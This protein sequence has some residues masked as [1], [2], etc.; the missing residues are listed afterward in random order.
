M[1]KRSLNEAISTEL[2]SKFDLDKFKDKKLLNKSIMFKE[3]EWLPLSAAAND[4]ISL[5]GI[6]LGQITLIRGHSD[7]GKTTLMIEAA[8]AA[9]KAGKLPVFIITEMKWNFSHAKEMGFQVEEII[10]EETKEISYTG[11]FLYVDRDNINTVED[12]AEF[13]LDLLNEQEKDNLPYDLVFLWDSVGSIPCRQSVE[14]GTNNPMWNAGAMSTQFGNFI[15]QKF[16][17]SRKVSSKYTNTMIAVNKIRV[18]VPTTPLSQPKMKNKGGDTMYWDAA[19]VITF[20]NITNSG[21]SKIKAQKDKK[22]VEFAKRTTISVDKNHITEASTRN[23]IIITAHGFIG[24]DPKELKKYKD[25]HSHE[26][27]ETLGGKDFDIVEEDEMDEDITNQS[28]D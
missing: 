17:H 3:Q 23:V 14:K 8:I 24:N 19:L 28:E 5:P 4:G 11:N 16:P 21:V 9:Q 22:Q 6:P 15:N 2:K 10:N 26:W 13:I 27:L 1:A 12:I 25:D 18:E 20:G 7:S